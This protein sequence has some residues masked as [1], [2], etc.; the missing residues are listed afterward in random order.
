[1]RLIGEGNTGRRKVVGGGLLVATLLAGCSGAEKP[2]T[3]PDFVTRQPLA[4]E[5]GKITLNKGNLCKWNLN[6]RPPVVKLHPLEILVDGRC[7]DPFDKSG[8]PERDA[9]I[10]VDQAP[11]AGS[12]NVARVPDGSI[13]KVECVETE[14]GNVSDAAGNFSNKWVKG[15]VVHLAP[16]KRHVDPAA[17]HRVGYVPDVNVGLV[18]NRRPQLNQQKQQLLTPVQVMGIPVHPT[19]RDIQKLSE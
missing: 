15:E 3:S 16:S 4:L 17:M 10:G 11:F 9:L 12:G 13:L 14:A 2:E 18:A 7:N 6:N 8:D 19:P 1:M 5:V